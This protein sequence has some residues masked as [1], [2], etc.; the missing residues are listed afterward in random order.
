MITPPTSL[1]T[2]DWRTRSVFLAG[3]IEMGKAEDWQPRAAKQLESSWLVLNPRR[4]D[5]D[6]SWTQSIDN[7]QF[8]EQVQWELEAIERCD[9]VLMYLAPGTMSPISLLEL[10][11]LANSSK[12]VVACPSD[13]WRSGNVE[14]VCC[15]YRV[16]LYSTLEGAVGHLRSLK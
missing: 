9:K 7:P 5:W 3:S 1:A 6:S 8:R 10:G 4:P 2:I 16:P 15:R 11:L 12:L 14:I 13:F